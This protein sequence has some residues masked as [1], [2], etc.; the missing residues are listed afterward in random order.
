MDS[1]LQRLCFHSSFIC[2]VGFSIISVITWKGFGRAGSMSVWI[3]WSS[4]DSS[5]SGPWWIPHC[6]IPVPP[7]EPMWLPLR[8]AACKWD[9]LQMVSME[10]TNSPTLSPHQCHLCGENHGFLIFLHYILSPP[11]TITIRLQEPFNLFQSQFC[12]L[13]NCIY[14]EALL[15]RMIE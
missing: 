4:S 13:L 1:A 3:T 5:G 9:R 12:Y 10:R 6:A 7:G 15:W 8:S 2:N 11:F 14:L